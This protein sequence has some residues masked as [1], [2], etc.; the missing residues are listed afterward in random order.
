M[1]SEF[2]LERSTT[3]NAPASAI[4]PHVA[5]FHAWPAWSPWEGQDPNLE[6]TYS[7]ADVGPGAEYSWKGNRKAGEGLMKVTGV[8]EPTV[9]NIHLEFVKPF[10]ATNAVVFEFTEG[11]SDATEVRWVMSGKRNFV[12]Q[13]FGVVFNLDKLVGKDFE[14]GLASLKRVVEQQPAAAS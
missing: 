11:H 3:I 7:G 14:K 5:D 2:T 13:I 6:R 12:M 1:A 10:K 9:I 8:N 4:Y